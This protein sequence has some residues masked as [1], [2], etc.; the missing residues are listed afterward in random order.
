MQ[1]TAIQQFRRVVPREHR[2]QVCLF[3][4]QGVSLP[5]AIAMAFLLP[6]VVSTAKS[7]PTQP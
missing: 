2:K 1:E 6:A 5:N 3:L 7:F 4:R